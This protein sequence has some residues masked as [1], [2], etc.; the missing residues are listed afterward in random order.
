MLVMDEFVWNN[1]GTIPT[2]ENPSTLQEICR[3][4]LCSPQNP[5]GLASEQIRTSTLISWQVTAM[6]QPE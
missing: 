1:G 5:Q 2:E 3:V 4:P 6:T